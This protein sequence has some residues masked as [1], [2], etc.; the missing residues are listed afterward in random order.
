MHVTGTA[1]GPAGKGTAR[2]MWGRLEIRVL[3]KVLGVGGRANEAQE[4]P[5]RDNRRRA[6]AENMRPVAFTETEHC[7]AGIPARGG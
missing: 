3:E 1:D 5:C 4:Q 6:G 2:G 7:P